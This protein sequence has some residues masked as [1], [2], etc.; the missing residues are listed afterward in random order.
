MYKLRLIFFLKLLLITLMVSNLEVNAQNRSRIIGNVKDADTKEALFG[1][2]VFLEGTTLGAATDDEG[3]FFIINVPVGSYNLK[4]SMIG[5]AAKVIQNVSISSDRVTSVDIE[6]QTTVLQSEEVVVVAKKT[7]LHKEVSSTQLVVSGQDMKMTTGVREINSFLSKLPGIGEDNG[8]LSIRGGSADQT[9]A[10]ING[11]SYVNSAVGNAET[12]IPLSAV[13]E[14]SLLS[15]GYTAE[16]GNFRS[17]LINVSTK[18]GSKSKYEGTVSFSMDQS[19][20]RRFGD[21]FYDPNNANLRSFL[22]PA[23]AF[24]GT[25]VAWQDDNYLRGQYPAFKGWNEMTRQYNLGRLEEEQATPL[26]MYL[27]AAWMH[28]TEPDYDA[29]AEQGYTVSDEQKRLFADHRM[30]EDGVDWNFDGGFGGPVPFIGKALGD[31]TFYISNVSSEKYYVMPVTLRSQKSYTTL[32]TIS[33]N[34]SSALSVS[35]NGL[36]KRQTGVSP[37]RPPWGDAPDVSSA[38]GFMP[39]DNVKFINRNSDRDVYWY[40]QS[41]YPILDQTTIMNGISMNYVLNKSSYF[42]FSINHLYIK[43]HS[44]NGDNRDTTMI[45][46]FGPFNVDEMPYG[47]WQ[48]ASKHEVDGYKYPSYDAL[49]GVFRR[50]RSKEGDLID[51]SKVEQVQAKLNFV[52]QI[53]SHNYLKTGIEYNYIDINH[54]F[55][56]IWN[57][58]AYNTYEFNYH[59]IPSQT[60]LYIQ[61]QIDYEGITANLG[62]RFDYYY[63]GGGRW[64]TGDPFSEMFRPQAVDTSLYSYLESGKSYIWDLWEKYDKEHPGFLQDIQNYFTVSPRVGLSFP[65]TV[66]SK[67]YFNY[68]QF[69]SNPPYYS[70]YQF[71]YRYDKNGV[72]EMSNP[73]LEPPRTTSYELGFAVNPYQSYIMR[74]SGYYKDVTGQHG[75]VQYI[76]E[77][78]NIDYDLWA[79]NEYEDIRGFEFSVEKSDYSWINFWINFNYM[80]SKSGN[81]GRSVVSDKTI[82]NDQEGLYQGGQSRSLPLPRVNANVTF[83]SPGKWITN[84][85]GGY[86][87][88]NWTM[89]IYGSWR[90]GSYF[91]YNPLEKPFLENN[92][93][94][95]DYYMVDLKISKTFELVGTKATFYVDISNLLNIK[96]IE[97]RRGYAFA[98]DSDES[99]YM[100]SLHLPMYNSSE[101]D[102]LR[103]ANPGYYI[104][105]DDKVGELR[106][107]EKPYI[108]DPNY[109]FFLFGRPRDIWFGVRVDF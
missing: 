30:K 74:L 78:G 22:D 35:Y 100:A 28:M 32:M 4:V 68:G 104:P 67:F 76:N 71:R 19:H 108:N 11:M 93:Q 70:M 87:L 98:T 69:R 5:Y 75:T 48:F 41:L 105:G 63:G 44:P 50:F 72:Y 109:D 49:P 2:N 34:P 24:V 33:S 94:Y 107:D 23:V 97:L 59:R 73:N 6:L 82:N 92:M 60:G 40:D 8:Y 80:L 25:E 14:V 45:T 37:V 10:M 85:L 18:S 90:T 66:D 15:G 77:V 20:M 106:S 57:Q 83:R 43:N 38:G 81:V 88:G 51:N 47:K 103:E 96:N 39:Q 101:F 89:S 46:A 1:A 12:T 99:L 7:S 31:A 54:H 55:F 27:L 26:D 53:N 36:W 9:G 42:D 95:P 17:G 79:N 13:E 91:T 56:E 3:N 86:L 16:Y 58:N 84:V 52:S 62:V 61:D 29:L 102:R 65:I 21:S 64:P